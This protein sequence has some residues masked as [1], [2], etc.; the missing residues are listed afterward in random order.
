MGTNVPMEY[1]F[2]ARNLV[3]EIIRNFPVEYWEYCKNIVE[4]HSS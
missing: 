3:F 4:E 1:I 2:C